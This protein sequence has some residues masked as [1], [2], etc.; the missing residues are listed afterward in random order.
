M[1]ADADSKRY[2]AAVHAMQTGV[3]LKIQ[4]DPTEASPKHLRVGIN[5]AMVETSALAKLLIEKG[6][7]TLDDWLKAVAVGMENEVKLYADELGVKPE[8]LA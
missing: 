6:V 1:S 3:A 5:S 4:R 2:I 8:N 7:I